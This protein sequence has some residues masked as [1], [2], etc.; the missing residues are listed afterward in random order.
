MNV[1]Y[2]FNPENDMAL[3]CGDPY[4]MPPANVR[5]M[6]AELSVLPAWYAEEGACV[7]TA[8]DRDAVWMENRVPLTLPVKWI[9]EISTIYNKVYPWGWNPSLVR[10]LQEKGIPPGGCPSP[11]RMERIRKLSGRQTAVEML[12][13]LRRDLPAFTVGESF[14]LHSLLEAEMFVRSYPTALLK[15]PWSGSGRGLRYT[16]GVFSSPLA[17]WVRHV[18]ATQCAVIGEPVCDKVLDFAM[19]FFSGGEAGIR[20]VGYSV[21]E[22]DKKGNYKENML[23][24]DDVMELRLAEY[25]SVETLHRLRDRLILE[26]AEMTGTDYQGYLG[27][28]MMICKRMENEGSGYAVH[29]CVEINLR[30]NMG[31]VARLV[32]DRY[33][34]KEAHGRYVIEYYPGP[35]EAERTHCYFQQRYPLQMEGGRV[36]A[37]YLSLTPVAEDTAYHAYII[38]E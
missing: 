15:A 29:P 1:L 6:A 8:S 7:L 35:G 32:Y 14:V 21:F 18:L 33:I 10:R 13:R 12:S 27:V 16:S 25:V 30:M 3:A 37:G 22:T 2:L 26:L 20:F 28:D 31:V 17:G 38:V 11:V 36:K 23:A 9:T 4:Y 5:R 24:S 19:E 34:Y